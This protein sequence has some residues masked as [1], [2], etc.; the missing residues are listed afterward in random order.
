[1]AEHVPNMPNTEPP[2]AQHTPNMWNGSWV[3]K[4]NAGYMLYSSGFGFFRMMLR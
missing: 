4:L 3:A 2:W 1:M